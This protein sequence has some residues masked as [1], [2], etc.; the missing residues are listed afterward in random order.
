MATAPAEDHEVIEPEI[1]ERVEP[2]NRLPDNVVDAVVIEDDSI[3]RM[4]KSTARPSDL[5]DRPRPA[6]QPVPPP[7]GAITPA[8]GPA[9]D[10]APALKA[11]ESET[12]ADLRLLRAD[13][14]LRSRV[15]AGAVVPF[16]LYALVLLVIGQLSEF[17]LWIWIPAIVAGVLMGGL[18]D[19]A[20]RRDHPQEPPSP[21]V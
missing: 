10:V 13:T 12:R 9:A 14:A 4:L 17:L 15:I 20:H 1:V 3:V 8:P 6:V 11:R 7:A 19:R 5:L 16:V 2:A 21:L 18:L